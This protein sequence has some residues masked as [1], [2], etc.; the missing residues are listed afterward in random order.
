LDT[1]F[2]PTEQDFKRW[3]KEAVEESIEKMI[4]GRSASTDSTDE[5]ISREEI[6][7][8]L[9]ISLVTLNEWMKEGLPFHK[10][11]RKVYF[12]KEEVLRYIKRAN[13]IKGKHNIETG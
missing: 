7:Q 12:I 13:K 3:I 6:A 1:L 10:P 2:I 9:D 4:S 5:L 8:V 11:K